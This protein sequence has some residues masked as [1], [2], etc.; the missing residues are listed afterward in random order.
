MITGYKLQKSFCTG[1]PYEDKKT[2][3]LTD[4]NN[5]QGP[6]SRIKDVYVSIDRD[7]LNCFIVI[8]KAYGNA[9]FFAQF[10]LDDSY[11]IRKVSKFIDDIGEWLGLSQTWRKINPEGKTFHFVEIKDGNAEISIVEGG[12]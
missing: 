8:D 6:V 7:N 9:P 12:K 1:T 3:Y 5:E 10:K 2:F 11:Y 4:G